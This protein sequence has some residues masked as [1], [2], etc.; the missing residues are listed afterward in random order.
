[1]A[2]VERPERLE[3]EFF[4]VVDGDG[5]LERGLDPDLKGVADHCAAW[6][7]TLGGR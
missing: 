6:Y 4:L 5:K 2:E 3:R 1:M 7:R